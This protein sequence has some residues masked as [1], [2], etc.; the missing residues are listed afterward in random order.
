MVTAARRL[1]SGIFSHLLC[2]Q[3]YLITLMQVWKL[4]PPV[5]LPLLWVSSMTGPT[6]RFGAFGARAMGKERGH[7]PNYCFS[8]FC[9]CGF[10]WALF[11]SEHPQHLTAILAHWGGQWGAPHVAAG[12]AGAGW[13]RKSLW[14]IYRQLLCFQI[15]CLLSSRTSKIHGFG[16]LP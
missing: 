14:S 5:C 1:Q 15:Q 7:L 10:R 13:P 11:S 2:L 8:L 12:C 16:K 3:M 6:Q 9:C 4:L